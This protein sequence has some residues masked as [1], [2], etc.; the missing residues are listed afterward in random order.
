MEPY[1]GTNRYAG[2]AAG[3]QSEHDGV[4]NIYLD[5]NL[6]N[7]DSHLAFCFDTIIRVRQERFDTGARGAAFRA[8][9]RMSHC[10]VDEPWNHIEARTDVLYKVLDCS[11][12]T[13]VE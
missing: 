12:N 5:L 6:F 9:D 7:F 1:R 10:A 13:T 8:R 3:L 2:Q 11:R 4:S